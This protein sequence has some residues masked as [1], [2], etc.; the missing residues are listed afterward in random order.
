M[1]DAI[2]TFFEGRAPTW[3]DHMPPDLDDDLRAMLAPFLADVETAESVLEIGTGT[4]ALIPHLLAAIPAGRL[5]SVDL[6]HG[7]VIRARQR[8]PQAR[9]LQ[10]DAHHLPGADAAFD[11]VLCHNSYPHFADRTRALAEIRRVLRPGGRLL[12]LHNNSRERVNAIHSGA[13]DAVA[14]DLLPP[15]ETLRDRLQN[16][17]YADV[18]V[19]DTPEH[20]FAR[21]VRP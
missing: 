11:V 10:A 15:G 2:R 20:Y 3:N 13:G 4:G 7:M 21:A 9:L 14:H 18:W 17:G 12:I 16:A 5:L 1:T 19:E 6:A 8:A